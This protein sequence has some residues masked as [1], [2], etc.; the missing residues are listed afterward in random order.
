MLPRR[1]GGLAKAEHTPSIQRRQCETKAS[2]GGSMSS[3]GERSRAGERVWSISEAN[4]AI[5]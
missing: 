3:R 1:N 2:L 5:M 4:N